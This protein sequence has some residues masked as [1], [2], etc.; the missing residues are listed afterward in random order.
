MRHI[1]HLQYVWYT[2]NNSRMREG[3]VVGFVHGFCEKVFVFMYRVSKN[4]L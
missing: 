3:L 1:A 4:I 2:T